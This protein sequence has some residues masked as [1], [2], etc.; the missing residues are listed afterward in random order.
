M[1]L[2]YQQ[3]DIAAIKYDCA[4]LPSNEELQADYKFMVKLY[5]DL[6]ENPLTPSGEQLF[7]AE[8]TPPSGAVEPVVTLFVSVPQSRRGNAGVRRRGYGSLRSR[9]RSATGAS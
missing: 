3:A 6:V 9:R 7:E 2:D 5:R 8:V 4:T 1:H